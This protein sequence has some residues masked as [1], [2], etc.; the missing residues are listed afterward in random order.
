MNKSMKNQ[1]KM[2]ANI[3]ETKNNFRMKKI[4]RFSQTLNF[5]KYSLSGK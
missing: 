4:L 3:L 1:R 5:K 2:N